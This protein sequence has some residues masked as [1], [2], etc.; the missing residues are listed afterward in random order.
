MHITR[1]EMIQIQ[2]HVE[3]GKTCEEVAKMCG[4]PVERIEA[5]CSNAKVETASEVVNT[6][7]TPNVDNT[8]DVDASDENWED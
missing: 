3:G 8:P 1:T 5:L 4:I 6:P 7:N 2:R